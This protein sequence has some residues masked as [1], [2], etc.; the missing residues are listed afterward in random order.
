[1]PEKNEACVIAPAAP[2]AAFRRLL[3]NR[4]A[5]VS[6]FFLLALSAFACVS[7]LLEGRLYAKPET[8]N[9]SLKLLPPGPGH[10]LGTDALGRDIL[11]RTAAGARISLFI[12]ILATLV[13]L[14]IGVAY[15][16]AAGYFGGAVDDLMMRVVDVLYAL[17]FIFLVILLLGLF[18]RSFLLLFAALGAVQWLTMARVVR[19]QVL[20]LRERDFVAAAR[21]TGA[22]PLRIL[23]RHILPNVAGIVIVYAT[24]TVPVIILQEAFL[25]FLGLTVPGQEHSW[26]VLVSEGIDALNPVK[27]A[28]WLIVFPGAAISSTLLALNFLGDGLRDAYDPRKAC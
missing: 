10:L 11:A 7:P 23:G 5:A 18:E 9:L 1:M 4:A 14:V 15:G 22:G 20:S 3:R 26:G 27:V 17:P 8:Q 25:S 13:T 24:L 19:G 16:A 2:P 21:A 28:W 6:L 12:G